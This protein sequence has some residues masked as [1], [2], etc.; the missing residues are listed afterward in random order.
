MKTILFPF[1]VP[2][3]PERGG[4]QRVGDILAKSLIK[5]GYNV[6]FLCLRFPADYVGYDYPV[7]VD[8]FPNTDY[9]SEE[10]RLFYNRYIVEN[11]VNIVVNNVMFEQSELFLTT[12]CN[13]KKVTVIHNKPSLDYDNLFRL[14]NNSVEEFFR[15]IIRVIIWSIKGYKKQY[16][17]GITKRLSFIIKNSDVVSLLSDKYRDDFCRFMTDVKQDKI[18]SIANPNTYSEQNVKFPKKQQLLF[19]GRLHG[20][21]KRPERLVAIWRKLYKKFP[22]WELVFV[23]DGPDKDR[24]EKSIRKLERVSLVGFKDAKPYFEEAS[25]FCMTSSFEGFPMVL[26]EAMVHGVVPV[27]FDSFAAVT[28]IIED[29]KNG[30]LVKPFSL[31]EYV[32]KLSLLMNENDRREKMAKYAQESVKKFD[33]DKITDAWEDL[34]CNIMRL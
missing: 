11:K 4:I 30:M 25:I 20:Y 29:D 33:V 32:T 8:L 16:K 2:F 1:T 23:G 19:V 34:F 9:K 28:D 22:N 27:A 24:I 5:R 18:V 21:S 17:N 6:L 14:R 15:R 31:S 13:V 10:N 3:H 12:D 26:T 7:K